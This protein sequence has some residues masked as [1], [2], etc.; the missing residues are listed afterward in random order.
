MG[1]SRLPPRPRRR[2]PASSAPSKVITMLPGRPILRRVLYCFARGARGW[3]HTRLMDKQ[4]AGLG[5]GP[6]ARNTEPLCGWFRCQTPCRTSDCSS[7]ATNPLS[8]QIVRA[9]RYIRMYIYVPIG[10]RRDAFMRA[11]KHG[12]PHLRHHITR[13]RGGGRCTTPIEPSAPK[14]ALLIIL[15]FRFAVFWGGFCQRRP[16]A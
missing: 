1:C 6:L 2:C 10:F 5:R 3:V 15:L 13:G 8:S 4:D 14:T 7:D 11:T 16:Q 9:L 12:L